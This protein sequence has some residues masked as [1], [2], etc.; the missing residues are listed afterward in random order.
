MPWKIPDAIYRRVTAKGYAVFNV[1]LSN[2]GSGGYLNIVPLAG[3][4]RP[5][6]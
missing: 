2:I 6:F 1:V 5:H 3:L 4:L